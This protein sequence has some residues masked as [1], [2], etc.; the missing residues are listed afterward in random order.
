MAARV[1]YDKRTRIEVKI[2]LRAWCTE[3]LLHHSYS[4]TGYLGL[5]SARWTVSQFSLQPPHEVAVGGGVPG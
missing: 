4:T 5:P 2:P 3:Q 1:D